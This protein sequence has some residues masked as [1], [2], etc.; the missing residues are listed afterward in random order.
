MEMVM[1]MAFACKLS[2]G[3]REDERAESVR[4]MRMEKV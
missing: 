2:L 1:A 3:N 4:A